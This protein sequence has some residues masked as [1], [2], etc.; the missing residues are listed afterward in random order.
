MP[1]GSPSRGVDRRSAEA[2]ENVRILLR[3]ARRR[4]APC[5]LRLSRAYHWD[6]S[7]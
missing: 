3:P 6:I 7:G 5:R 4:S 2:V 1:A